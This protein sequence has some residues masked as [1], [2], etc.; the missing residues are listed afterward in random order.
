MLLALE[1]TTVVNEGENNIMHISAII[2]DLS[3]GT[4]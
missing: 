1:G 4:G 2:A 3:I